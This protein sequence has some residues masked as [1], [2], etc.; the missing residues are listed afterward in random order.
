M[1]G[2]VRTLTKAHGYLFVVCFA[3]DIFDLECV[4]RLVSLLHHE[5]T[6]D[7]LWWI[8]SWYLGPSLGDEDPQSLISNNLFGHVLFRGMENYK[9]KKLL[10]RAT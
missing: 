10:E 5:E 9:S 4:N 6:R 2:L 1:Y 3:P 8:V 7:T